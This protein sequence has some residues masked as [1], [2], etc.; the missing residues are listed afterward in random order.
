MD[1]MF[2]QYCRASFSR[3]EIDVVAKVIESGWLTTGPNVAA[4]ESEFK[5]YV[6]S[7]HAIA[8]NSCTGGLHCSLAALG[9]GPGDEVITTPLTFVATGHT[10]VWTG[11]KPVLVD[12]DPKTYNIDPVRVE[13]AV[14]AKTRAILPVHYAG[15]P[16]DM[17]AIQDIARRRKLAVIE[18]AAHAAGSEYKGKKIGVVGDVTCFSFYPTKN[19]TSG[20][21]G[22]V[23]TDD[24]ALAE[25]IRRFAFFG[26]SRDVWERYG[27]KQSWQYDVVL[28]GFKYN[29][30]D[31]LAAIGRVQLRKLDEFNRRREDMARTLQTRLAP[32]AEFIILPPEGS[33][34]M[35]H[36]WHLFPVQM[37]PARKNRD[38]L[39]EF[40]RQ[41]DI[42]SSVH[43]IPLHLF[44]YYQKAFGYKK[45][46]FPETERV[47]EN[48][49]SIPLYPALSSKDIDRIVSA[50]FAFFD[51]RA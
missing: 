20:E 51:K 17:D 42:G 40:L 28:P 49:L 45:G 23:T 48:I 27:K 25:R 5:A 46:D 19:M 14:T 2:I 11:A 39:I 47:F 35:R 12:I 41:N 30:A 33:A 13:K 36:N 37:K 21:G 16:C 24:D 50:M 15:L 9:V 29:M 1:E 18:D 26:I 32:L 4:F 38:E 44:D 7:K 6:G 22:M 3:E 8:L 31:V 34:H 10:I 43:F